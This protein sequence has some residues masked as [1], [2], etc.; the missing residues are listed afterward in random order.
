MKDQDIDLK[1]IEDRLFSIELRLKRMEAALEIAESGN[2]I[3][4]EENS[5]LYYQAVT[6]EMEE[7]E[8]GL[9]SRI[10][11]FGL[12]WLGNIVLLFGIT[13]LLQYLMNLDQALISVVIGYSSATAIFFLAKHLKK[14]NTHLAF[15]F[16]MNG[17]ILLF[18]ITMRLYFFSD[19]PLIS[20]KTIVVLLLMIVAAYQAYW[21]IRNKSQSLSVI[22]VLF[23]LTTAMITDSTH[24]MLPIITVTAIGSVYYYYR[25][26]WEPL[27]FVTMILAY[28]SFFLWLFG[29]PLMGHQM[30]M[31][32]DHHQG[33]IYLFLLGACYSAMLLFRQK[34]S[35]SDDFFVGVTF[36]SG[37]IFTLLLLLVVMRYFSNDYVLLF[38]VI[39]VCCLIFSTL[40]HSKSEWNFG[41]A[42]YAL[43]GFMAMSIAL[44]G[45]YGF[46]KVYLL[47]SVQS[48]VVVSM[49]L[50]FRNR[51]IV[52]MNSLLFLSIL[53]VYLVSSKPIDSVNYSFALIALISARIINWQKS[54]L[55]IETDMMRN[56]YLMEGFVMVLLALYHSV[57]KHFITLSWTLAALSYFLLSI[58][59]KNV[60]YRYLALG[61][62][63]CAALYLFLVDLAKIELIYRVLALLFLSAIS[64]GISMYYTNK[65]KNSES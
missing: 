45:L 14:S 5:Q 27:L 53:L 23:V 37:I 30:V 48:L 1:G 64:I 38:T 18:Y 65:I 22:S 63:I 21:A 17:Q 49:A 61:T 11:S 8:K 42:Y 58:L 28:L 15:M 12:A 50:W 62:M 10:G 33:I 57:P 36:T 3:P 56:L 32:S 43:Y 6:K 41:S 60:K 35:A 7:E 55:K 59:L 51:L 20:Q 52:I 4:Y 31:I 19:A 25:Y 29:N 39:T 46:P 44:Y 34:E 9:E 54:R 13:F 16:K 47:L 40:L 24:L 26:R 2:S